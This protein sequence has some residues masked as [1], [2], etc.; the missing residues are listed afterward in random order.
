MQY[1]VAKLLQEPTGSTRSFSFKK[2]SVDALESPEIAQ[3]EVRFLR[4]HRGILA[5]ADIE[6]AGNL[7]CSRCLSNFAQTSYHHIEEEFLPEIDLQTG[8]TIEL[9][10]EDEPSFSISE[11][12]TID[13]N[14]ALRQYIIGDEPMKPLC[15]PGCLGLCHLCGID[16][17][18]AT[19][20][21]EIYSVDPRWTALTGFMNANSS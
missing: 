4:T 19:C 20:K 13:L 5:Y 14:E 18:Q 3:G 6:V 17:N 15:R 8:R 9:L 21:C 12:H 7:A 2:T 1:N 10:S 16:L 11:D